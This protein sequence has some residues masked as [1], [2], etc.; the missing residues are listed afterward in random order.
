MERQSVKRFGWSVLW[1]LC[2][3]SCGADDLIR[4]PDVERWCG[5][6]PCDWHVEGEIKRVSTWHPNDYAVALVSDDAALIQENGTVDNTD[7]DCFSFTMVAK[8]AEGVKVF[9]ELDF[10]ADGSVEFSQRLPVSDWERRTFKVTAPDWYRKV[11]FIIRKEGPGRAILAEIAAENA[12]R[13]CTAPPIE[14]LER[15]E[16]AV[17]AKAEQCGEGMECSSGRC[18]GCATDEGC[19]DGQLCAIRDE[20]NQ[21]FKTCVD[22]NSTPLGA[23]C[24]RDPQCS[25]GIC[26]EGACSE[27]LMDTDCPSGQLCQL[28]RDRPASS[29]FWPRL[30]GPGAGKRVTDEPCTND[31]DCVSSECQGFQVSCRVQLECPNNG[32]ACSIGGC[33]PEIELGACR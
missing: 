1:A 24:D 15:P 28:A 21:R 6:N 31:S 26:N 30:C 3:L 25:S 23:A 27:C 7:S 9:L 17:C 11:R 20:G 14:L 16:G 32:G 5:D 22:V 8:I 10:L 4:N 18:G 33:G 2:L 19:E 12:N 13:Q 29:R